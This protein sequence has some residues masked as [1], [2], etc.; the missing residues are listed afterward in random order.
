MKYLTKKALSVIISV[1]ILVSCIAPCIIVNINAENFEPLSAEIDF[2]SYTVNPAPTSNDP[3]NCKNA[4]GDYTGNWEIVDDANALGGK[5]LHK[6]SKGQQTAPYLYVIQLNPTGTAADTIALN[7]DTAYRVKI[8]HKLDVTKTG[9]A[10]HLYLTHNTSNAKINS[11]TAANVMRLDSFAAG[12]GTENGDWVESTYYIT[13]PEYKRYETSSLTLGLAPLKENNTPQNDWGAEWNW[14]VDYVTVDAVSRV[15]VHCIDASGKDTLKSFYGVPGEKVE[16]EGSVDYYENYDS[17]T[18]IFSNPVSGEKVFTVKKVETLYCF[19]D[20]FEKENYLID[21]SKYTVNPAP[22][23]NNPGNCK[24]ATGDYIGNWEIVDDANALGGKVLHKY[25]KGQQT[26]HYLYVIQLNPTGTAADTVALSANVTYK[27]KIRHKLDITKTGK[28]LYLYLT[29]NT[30]NVKINS[31]AAANV[32]RLDSFAAGTGTEN[33]DWVESTYY[34]TVPE[35]QKLDTSSLTLGLAPL[36]ENNAPQNDWAAEWDWYVD[37][38]AIE[39][40]SAVELYS[41]G[42]KIDTLYGA[43]DDVL[44]VSSISAPK[45]TGYYF[46]GWFEDEACSISATTVTYRNSNIS[47]KLYAGWKELVSSAV[48]NQENISSDIYN[49]SNK[50]NGFSSSTEYKNGTASFKSDIANA[51]M[52]LAVGEAAVQLQN[53]GV[54]LMSFW[55]K[56]A[57]AFK[58]SFATADDSSFDGAVI[59]S[60]IELAATDDW[61]KVFITFKADTAL[62]DKLYFTVSSSNVFVDDIELATVSKIIFDTNGGDAISEITG[63]PGAAVT[64]PIATFAGHTFSGWYRDKECTRR[65][66][67]AKYPTDSDSLTLY[68]GWDIKEPWV[69]VSFDNQTFNPFNNANCHN[70]NKMSIVSEENSFDGSK[71]L[72]YTHV[73]GSGAYNSASSSLAMYSTQNN[74]VRLENN[75]TYALSFWYKATELSD[76]VRITAMTNMEYNFWLT[77]GQVNYSGNGY[78]IPASESGTDWKRGTIYFTTDLQK[79]VK[80]GSSFDGKY[81]DML[82]FRI[83]VNSDADTNILFDNITVDKLGDD[84][85]VITKVITSA[86][87]EFVLCEKN[88]TLNLGTPSVEGYKFMGWFED[89]DYTKPIKD[90]NYAVKSHANVY[91]KW[92]LDYVSGSFEDYPLGWTGPDIN[93]VGQN[94][95]FPIQTGLSLVQNEASSGSTSVRYKSFAEAKNPYTYIQLYNKN[96]IVVAGDIPLIVEEGMD[97]K[98]TIKYKLASSATNVKLTLWVG[99][100]NNCWGDKEK[101]GEYIVSYSDVGK[102]WQSATIFFNAKMKSPLN[103]ALYIQVSGDGATTDIYLDDFT[104][105]SMAGKSFIELR[106]NNGENSTYIVGEVGK[107][108]GKLITPVRKGYKFLGWYTDSELKD[109]YTGNIFGQTSL[110][111]Y[112][113][114]TIEDEIVISFED[115]YYRSSLVKLEKDCAEVSDDIASVGK[116]SMKIDKSEITDRTNAGLL[117]V[118]DELPLTIEDNTTYQITYDYYVKQNTATSNASYTPWPNVRTGTNGNMWQNSFVPAETWRFPISEQ[119]G[120]WKTATFMFTTELKDSKANVLYFTVNATERFIGYFDNIRIKKVV[121][122]DNEYAVSLNTTGAT[123]IGKKPLVYVGKS[124]DRVNLPTDLKREGYIFTGWYTN[125]KCTDIIAD[126][127]FSFGGFDQTIYAGWAS[128]GFTQDFENFPQDPKGRYYYMD[129]DYEIYDA[130]ANGNSKEN[131]HGGNYSLHR[132]GEDYHNLAAQVITSNL[133]VSLSPGRVYRL[134]MWVKLEKAEHNKGALAM[135]CSSLMT[136]AWAVDGDWKNMVTI[137][138]LND[139]KWHEVTY[140]FYAT[141]NYLSILTPGNLSLFIDDIS[142][143]LLENATAEDCST[144]VSCEEYIPQPIDKDGFKTITECEI[145]ISRIKSNSAVK[146]SVGILGKVGIGGVIGISVGCAVLVATIVVFAILFIKNRKKRVK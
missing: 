108:I 111:L 33:E 54:Y 35:Y 5:V 109:I 30:S 27:V 49:N 89:T 65:V 92:S 94:F 83:N 137:A 36:N 130:A 127:I 37:Y 76:D 124:G 63:E 28:E 133:N 69:T 45:R 47:K 39:R 16:L 125:K 42:K 90:G 122:S 59:Q 145:D 60:S 11:I 99:H 102:G 58:A 22:T 67:V 80:E 46:L 70:K 26:T 142:I 93:G 98:F 55:Y 15:D 71:M 126:N 66:E 53:E 141:S 14:Y 91:A 2:S 100:R 144:S 38:V 61:K 51:Y 119:T 13:V 143:K 82:F 107:Q 128:L 105:E 85:V 4:T 18:N 117:L 64:L 7:A 74:F 115:Y 29:H 17:A 40:A 52:Q 106:P 19:D 97:Y 62:K 24:N 23:S 73:K 21:Y 9:K 96:D 1:I 87:N 129:F 84:I 134:S 79:Y 43:P 110:I 116:Y 101:A 118:Y 78:T 135:A 104:V 103:D 139:N 146:T 44:D 140:T 32:I 6:Y 25:S 81:C 77:S 34:I 68:A 131:V 41:D 20:S 50:F 56:S 112:A 31:L 3:G 72:K 12:K 88:N 114:W 123:D 113:K 95:R 138:D 136:Y 121:R 132:K 86:K 48:F 10:L 8:R 75:T 57:S 120:V